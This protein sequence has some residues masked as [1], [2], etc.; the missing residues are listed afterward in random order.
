M[1]TRTAAGRPRGS[2]ARLDEDGYL[3]FSGLL[4]RDKVLRLRRR[5]LVALRDGGGSIRSRC[6]CAACGQHRSGYARDDGVPEAYDEVQKL[7]EFHTLAHD[8]AL[9]DIMR[10]GG[11]RRPRSRTR[12]RSPGWSSPATTR[13][14]RRRTRTTRTT[15]ARRTSPRRGSRSATAR[16]SWAA[17]RCCAART[18]TACSRSTP[19]LGAGQP[20][21]GGAARDARGAAAG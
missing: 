14:R 21:G 3:Y 15:R 8:E 7:E 18:A 5:M 20:P 19:H 11:R 6:S 1:R 10:A 2:P 9:L 12:S 13:S 17:W 16:S 4:D